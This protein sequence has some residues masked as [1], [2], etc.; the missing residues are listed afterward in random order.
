MTTEEL[1]MFVDE[2]TKDM[3]DTGF[4]KQLKAVLTNKAAIEVLML[5]AEGDISAITWFIN[6]G[7]IVVFHAVQLHAIQVLSMLADVQEE[8][9]LATSRRN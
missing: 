8:A 4:R 2:V 7:P 6:G 1:R 9:D 5:A 3:K